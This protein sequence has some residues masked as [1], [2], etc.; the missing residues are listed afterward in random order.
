[1]LKHTI[2]IRYIVIIIYELTN[3]RGQLSL[4]PVF[5]K[6]SVEAYDNGEKKNTKRYA[7]Q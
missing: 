6:H 4:V 7:Y 2:C 5:G 1:M 3:K